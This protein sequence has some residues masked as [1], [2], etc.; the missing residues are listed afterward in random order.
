MVRN[1]LRNVAIIAH[2]D[3]G[4]TTLVD[5]LLRQSGA[6][7]DN[8]AV[9]ERVMDSGDIERERGITILAKNCSCTY[10]GVKINIVDTPGH[11]DFGGE[12]ERIL[13]MVNGVILLVDAAE[14]PMPQTRFVLRHAIDT[15][16]KIMIVINKIDRPG[17]NPEKAYNDCLDLMADLGATDDQLEFAMEHVVYASAMNGFARLD[18]NDGNMDMYPLL[19]M[20][21][22]D[23]PAPEVDENAPLAMQCVTIDHSNFVGRIGIGRVYSGTIHQGD[24]ILVVKNDGSSATATVKQLFTFDYLGRTECQEVG[25]GDIAAVVGIDR[26]DIGD[27]YTD[28]ENPVELEP[29]EIDPP[30]LS[31]VF[32]ASTSP[33][34]GRDGDIVGAR[35]LKERLFN[36][37]ENNVTMKIEELEDKS[38]VEVSGR[39]ILHLSVLME[40]MRREGFE[41]QVGRPRVL[42]KKDENG[43]KMEPVEQAVVE[44]PDEYSGKV[45]EVFGTSGGIMT[46]MD[47]SG[48]V[49]H[50]EFKIPT[51]GIMGLKNRIMNVTHGEGVFYHTFLEYGPYAGEIGNRQNGAMISMT[52]EKAVAYAL[53]TLQE[54]GQLF[55]E[56]GTECYKGMIVGERSKAGDMVVNI[57]RTKNLGNQRSSTSDISVQL[58]PPRTFSLEEAL[59]Y[60]ADDELVEITPKNIRLRKRLL[61]ATDRKKAAVRAGQVNK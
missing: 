29:I 19:D 44:C 12:V 9:A 46:S 6:F 40:S 5:A 11:A 56:P 20:I 59:E 37:A 39:G 22:D 25:A 42:F 8:Q 1:D 54:R 51:R 3:H 13:K 2:V 33:L 49:T 10:K 43:N 34:V 41:F 35:Q 58:V 7:R 18:P 36:E 45:V 15:G 57:A 28:P 60:I 16:L 14:G 27:V 38:G 17:A 61:N 23:M 32:E 26:T 50:L 4:K 21:I 52:T 24:Q 31:I 47:T 30:T 55:V 53:G 48:I